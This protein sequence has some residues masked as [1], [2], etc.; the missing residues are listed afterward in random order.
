MFSRSVRLS[1]YNCFYY[2][3]YII[4]LHMNIANS[5]I[6]I[7]LFNGNCQ[8]KRTID[9]FLISPCAKTLHTLFT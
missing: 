6:W 1:L 7:Y 4:N 3:S 5:D 9:M 8:S 2:C